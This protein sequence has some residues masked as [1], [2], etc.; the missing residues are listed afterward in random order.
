MSTIINCCAGSAASYVKQK[1]KPFVTRHIK[2][3]CATLKHDMGLWGNEGMKENTEQKLPNFDHFLKL[4]FLVKAFLFVNMIWSTCTVSEN[5]K[6]IL[7]STIN[8]L[9]TLK[10][11]REFWKLYWIEHIKS[12]SR[13]YLMF[14]LSYCQGIVKTYIWAEVSMR[15]FQ[16]ESCS[17]Q[18]KFSVEQ[19]GSNLLF[20]LFCI[21]TIRSVGIRV[22]ATLVTRFLCAI[23]PQLLAWSSV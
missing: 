21:Y 2:N 11:I 6:L 16:S 17:M 22:K 23:H 7:F 8:N 9:K 20:H 1:G 13:L 12:C 15:S 18:K 5:L 3:Y 14:T 19:I 10:K 4:P